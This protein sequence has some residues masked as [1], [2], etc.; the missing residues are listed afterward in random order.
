M[1]YH[2]KPRD[3]LKQ[4]VAKITPAIVSSKTSRPTSIAEYSLQL[5]SSM[6]ILPPYTF[7]FRWSGLFGF[8]TRFL[9]ATQHP[10][11]PELRKL[12]NANAMYRND[13]IEE[14]KVVELYEPVKADEYERQASERELALQIEAIDEASATRTVTLRAVVET[15]ED[16]AS[17]AASEGPSDP[18]GTVP[19]SDSATPMITPQ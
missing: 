12:Y 5:Q 17:D 13:D 1:I 14:N 19:P 7:G 8:M 15:A 11:F 16:A 18:P 9:K 3:D 10:H 4:A 6:N 2:A